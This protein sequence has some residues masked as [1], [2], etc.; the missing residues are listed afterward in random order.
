MDLPNELVPNHLVFH[1]LILE[2]CIGYTVSIIPLEGLRVDESIY[3]EEVPVDTLD[4]QVIE[5][6]GSSFCKGF[7]EKSSI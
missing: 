5:I 3:Y 2:K 6:Q 7:M 1:V 4:Q